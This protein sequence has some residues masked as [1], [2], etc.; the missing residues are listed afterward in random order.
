MLGEVKKIKDEVESNKQHFVQRIEAQTKRISELEQTGIIT[1]LSFFFPFP[2]PFLSLPPF[3][4]FPFIHFFFLI[5]L[6]SL[7]KTTKKSKTSN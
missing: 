6:H 2:F 1:T 3:H 7:C 4:P 5:K